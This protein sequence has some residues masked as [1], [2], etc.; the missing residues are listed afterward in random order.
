MKKHTIQLR[1]LFSG[2]LFCTFL[3]AV[4]F[5]GMSANAQAAS[6]VK[7]ASNA[8]VKHLGSMNNKEYFSLKFPNEKG[9]KFSVK[10]KDAEGNLIFHDVFQV[11]NFDRSFQFEKLADKSKLTFIVRTLKDNA[12]QVF[13]INTKVFTVEQVE[14]TRAK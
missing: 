3:I 1:N 14:I 6:E 11:K 2:K 8:V 5:T 10:V 7:P 13:Q 12:E 9:E 4:L